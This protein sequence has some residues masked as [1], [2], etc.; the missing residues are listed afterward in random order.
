M[1]R[2]R[3]TLFVVAISAKKCN[4][5]SF[6]VVIYYSEASC[7]GKPKTYVIAGI[8]LTRDFVDCCS[9]SFWSFCQSFS[10]TLNARATPLA[11]LAA[12]LYELNYCCP[13]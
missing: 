5:V 4:C 6:S 9:L 10:E 12:V 11:I 2:I 7:S 8:F 3:C 13:M 1:E